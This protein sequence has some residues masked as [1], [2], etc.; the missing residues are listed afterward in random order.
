M[1]PL[2]LQPEI[3][4]GAVG[5]TNY[6]SMRRIFTVRGP[7]CPE[8]AEL[9]ETISDIN[10]YGDEELASIGIAHPMNGGSYC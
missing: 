10:T 2:E 9:S 7:D 5:D 3:A 6:S 4:F 1:W 8:N